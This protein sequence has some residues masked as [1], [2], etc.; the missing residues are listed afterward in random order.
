M[1]ASWGPDPHARNDAV[2]TT[3]RLVLDVPD[4]ADAATLYELA[5]GPDRDAVCEML[6][7][8]G[9]DDVAEMETW[10]DRCRTATFEPFGFHWVLRDRTGDLTGTPGTPLGSAGTRPRHFRGRADVGYWLGK[11]YWGQGLMAEAVA[12]VLRHDFDDLGMA[13]VEADVF[14]RNARGIRLVEKLGFSREALLRRAVWKHG[15]W[16]DE[17]VYGIVPGELAAPGGG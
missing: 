9:P 7:W 14:T 2:L 15:E 1:E 17:Y 5:G 3:P 11:P 10:I 12:A 16:L 8:E 6:L 4:P 13:K